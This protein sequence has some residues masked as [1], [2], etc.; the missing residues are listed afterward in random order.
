[1]RKPAARIR[2]GFTLVELLVVITIIGI[3]IALLLPAVQA[4][5]EA[6]RI[7]QCQNNIKQLALGC[8][9][10]ESATKRLPTDGWGTYWTGDADLGNGQQQ[11]A[12][13]FYNILPFIEQQAMHDMGARLPAA[14]K[15]VANFQR[16]SIAL[17]VWYCPTRRK[18]LAYPYAANVWY[19]GYYNCSPS[20]PVSMARNDY[21]INGGDVYTTPGL[22]G[23]TKPGAKWA[24]GDNWYGGP[25]SLADGGVP[26]CSSTQLTRVKQT[27]NQVAQAATGVS[28]CGSLIKLSDVTDGASQT[29]LLGEKS[30]CPDYYL[31]GM[32]GGD[33]EEALEGDNEDL[34][35]W[36]AGYGTIGLPG[37]YLPPAMDTPGYV[38]PHVFG[39]AHLAGVSMALCDGSVR[40]INYSIDPETHRRLGNRKDGLPIDAKKL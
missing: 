40:M 9:H 5:R 32:D 33:N 7:A 15:N 39:S 31:N 12:G 34:A 38:V 18:A 36:T 10:H 21:A 30:L 2:A 35:R 27:F 17:S 26:P 23:T 25:A 24:A 19:H 3:L 16:Q 1:M 8:L 14:Q 11:P 28:Y 4:A 20:V 22:V 29:Y 13:W 6:A 37:L